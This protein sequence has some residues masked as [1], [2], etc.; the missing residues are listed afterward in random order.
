MFWKILHSS[1][2][3]SANVVGLMKNII[4]QVY[5]IYKSG[6]E[7]FDVIRKENFNALLVRFHKM[8]SGR[9]FC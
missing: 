6:I 8:L 1:V 7:E 9:A 4:L 5:F 2:T 3:G